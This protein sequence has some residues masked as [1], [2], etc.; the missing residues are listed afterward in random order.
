[1]K[2]H[3]LALVDPC[4]E[5]HPAVDRLAQVGPEM[6]DL[7]QVSILVIP[8]QDLLRRQQ[9]PDALIQDLE[10]VIDGLKPLHR[11]GLEHSVRVSWQRD[12]A[13]AVLDEVERLGDV[14]HIFAPC[15]TFGEKQ[16]LSEEM[17]KLIRNT[18]IPFTLMKEGGSRERKR[19]LAC[20]KIQEKGYEAVNAAVLKRANQLVELYGAE[21]YIVNGYTVSLNFPDRAKIVSMSGIPNERIFVDSH[22]AAQVIPDIA[23][24][25]KADLV[26]IGARRR[27][28][29]AALRGQVIEDI[30]A[31]ISQDV[32][33]VI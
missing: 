5:T 31:N 25:V 10:H 17:W 15:H 2:R 3:I 30:I 9:R 27:T 18:S 4:Q 11:A 1:M 32:T 33:I 13:Q 26:V 22:P 7:P 24:K 16:S 28:G 19:V 12:W 6:T 29:L 8:D 20:I 14:T 21:I 23:N